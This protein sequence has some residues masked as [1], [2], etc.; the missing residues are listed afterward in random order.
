MENSVSKAI[1]NAQQFSGYLE[2]NG[3][4]LKPI[5]LAEMCSFRHRQDMGKA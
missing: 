5:Y 3:R 1:E 2:F 4:P